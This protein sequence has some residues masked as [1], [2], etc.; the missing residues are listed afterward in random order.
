VVRISLGFAMG[1]KIGDVN[2]SELQ[3]YFSFVFAL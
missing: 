1:I 2:I 3:I